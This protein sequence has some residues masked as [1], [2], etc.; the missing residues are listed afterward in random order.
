[1]EETQAPVT[2]QRTFTNA[3]ETTDYLPGAQGVPVQSSMLLTLSKV[4]CMDSI[5]LSSARLLN[6]VLSD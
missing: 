3:L 1:M 6:L 4:A 5:N 2:G